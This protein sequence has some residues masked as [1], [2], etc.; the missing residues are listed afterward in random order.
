MFRQVNSLVSTKNYLLIWL[1]SKNSKDSEFVII[2]YLGAVDVELLAILWIFAK[3]KLH[4]ISGTHAATWW[5][6]LVADG[7][8]GSKVSIKLIL[9]V[10]H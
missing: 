10:Q 3:W 5:Q 6:K 1:T 8:V 7:S 4:N 9:N 2:Y